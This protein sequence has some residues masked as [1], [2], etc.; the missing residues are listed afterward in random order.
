VEL[1]AG[2]ARV[3]ADAVGRRHFADMRRAAYAPVGAVTAK[4][5]RL[6]DIVAESAADGWKVVVFSQFLDVIAAISTALAKSP[7][8]VLTGSTSAGRRQEAI[9][10]FTAHHGHLVLIGQIQ[11]IGEGINL[12]AASVVVLAEPALKPST[13]EQAIRRV[14]RMGQARSVQVH[15]L[16]AKDSVD[17]HLEAMLHDKRKLFRAYAHESDA[18]RAHSSATDSS[19][20]DYEVTDVDRERIIDAETERLRRENR[21]RL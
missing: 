15:R 1:D 13:E 12:Q 11:A 14:Y 8:M 6:R 2:E 10:R 20:V 4:L 19:V 9:D 16:L 3:Y 18:K 7:Q 21:S 17:G 5:D